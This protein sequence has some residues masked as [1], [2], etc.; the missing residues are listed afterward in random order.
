[1]TVI[2]EEKWFAL[3]A[4]M[5]KL[6]IKEAE[7][8]EKFVL[9]SGAGG[10]KVNKTSSC[11]HLIHKVSGIDIRCQHSRSQAANRFFARRELC[12]RVEEKTAGLKSKKEQAREKVRRQKRRRSRRSKNRM[13][14]DKKIQGNKKVSRKKPDI[15]ND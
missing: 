13:L 5:E 15:R 10:Q 12:D 7:L 9:G 1:M 11:V 2:S 6:A 3:R 14:D 4:R 8:E